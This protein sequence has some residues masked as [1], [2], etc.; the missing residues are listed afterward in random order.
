MSSKNFPI[1]SPLK[2]QCAKTAILGEQL[3]K[4][5]AQACCLKDRMHRC[6][7]SGT[8][9]VV[10]SVIVRQIFGRN[11][12]RALDSIATTGT[13]PHNTCRGT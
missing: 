7:I 5:T 6:V 3:L 8:Q 11:V 2:F 13:T 1:F 4:R 10:G 9:P 12:A